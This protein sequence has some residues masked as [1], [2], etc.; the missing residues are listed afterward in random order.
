MELLKVPNGVYSLYK[1]HEHLTVHTSGFRLS[2]ESLDII[3][4]AIDTFVDAYIC[5][6]KLS[7]KVFYKDDANLRMGSAT[8]GN[9]IKD[10]SIDQ[11]VGIHIKMSDPTTFN[12]KKLVKKIFGFKDFYA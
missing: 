2:K 12:M 7:I 5:D 4:R 6:T 10:K 3:N 8:Y 1:G 9:I 11:T